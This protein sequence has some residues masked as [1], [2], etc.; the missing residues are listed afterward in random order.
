MPSMKPQLS[1]AIRLAR[2]LCIVLLVYAHAQLCSPGVPTTV[3][4]QETLR[5]HVP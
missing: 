3:F 2:M 1:E 5:R 4:S